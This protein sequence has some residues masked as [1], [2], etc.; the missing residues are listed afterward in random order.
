MTVARRPT[1]KLLFCSL[2]L[3]MMGCD[4]LTEIKSFLHSPPKS[5]FWVGVFV[6]IIEIKLKQSPMIYMSIQP[7][8]MQPRHLQCLSTLAALRIF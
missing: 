6:T 4:L 7:P 5:W 3:L 1:F 2:L 8:Q